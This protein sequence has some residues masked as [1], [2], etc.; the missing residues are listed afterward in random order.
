[1]QPKHEVSQPITSPI[2]RK[3]A[4]C[5]NARNAEAVLCVL[6]HTRGEEVLEHQVW[7]KVLEKKGRNKKAPTCHPR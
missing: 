7:G 5:T 3:E 2:Q 6:E 4:A 1:M